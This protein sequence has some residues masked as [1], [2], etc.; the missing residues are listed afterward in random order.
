MWS[1]RVQGARV[2]G[3]PF[4]TG[5]RWSAGAA[6]G[7][8]RGAWNALDFGPISGQSREVRTIEAG[9]QGPGNKHRQG[10][11]IIGRCGL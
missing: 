5:Q 10:I 2:W 4:A 1:S 9:A 3:L 11:T 8:G 7:D 6:H